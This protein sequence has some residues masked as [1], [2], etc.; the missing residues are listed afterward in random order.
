MLRTIT[1]AEM[2]R[3]ETRVM[4]NT[5]LSGERLMQNAAAHVARAVKRL[6]AGRQGPVICFCGNG[7]NGG[8]GLAAMRM[9]A[10]EDPSFEGACRMLS[11]ALSPDAQRE[12]DRLNAR[13]PH[14]A[15]TGLEAPAISRPACVIDAL[16]GTGL[17]RPLEGEALAACRQINAWRAQGVP[18]VAVDIPSGLSGLT[19][20]VL[21]EAVRATVTVTFHRPK[22]G[23][24]LKEGPDYTGEIV[25]ADIGLT[26]P[27][28]AAYDDAG[29][30]FVRQRS[31][32]LLPARRR[33]AHKG[34]FGKV[35]LWV[36]SRGMA[37]A[38]ALCATAALRT[39]AGLV[40]VA[41]PEAVV[42]VVQTLCP[43]ATCLPLPEDAEAAWALLQDKL[44]WADAL[45]AGCG[46]GT[47]AWAKALLE[48]LCVWMDGHA[49]PAVLDA[50]ALNLLSASG[51]R[52]SGVWITP[53]PAEAARLLG[54]HTADVLAEPLSAARELARRYGPTV[55][56]GA[57]SVLCAQGEMALNPFGTPAMAKGGSGDALT[58][59]LA[60]L[61]AGRAAGAYDLAD[62]ALLQTACALHGLAGE[63][64]ERRF[65]ERGV[66]ATDLCACLGLV[67][68]APP[69]A[70][71][72]PQPSGPLC[73]WVTVTVE[74]P[75]GT[76]EDGPLK[77]RY[78]ANFGYIQEVLA[79]ENEWQDACVLGVDGPVEWMEGEVSALAT[80]EDGRQIWIVSPL[81][82][83]LEA[84]AV[85]QTLSF[86][87]PVRDIV[88]PPI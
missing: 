34:C 20:H 72:E 57:C 83:R 82:A 65:G 13:A 81:G 87:G 19:G 42:D 53:H 45:G 18:V 60:A 52:P 4:Q 80:L 84:E 48:R 40:V 22:P 7:N 1:P 36:G 75:R 32:P 51:Q 3:V 71:R 50:D 76:L 11:G 15:V 41:C 21:G 17:S 79:D 49:L 70:E 23:L 24:Y 29:G 14:I 88:L 61:L 9:L 78:P 43:C 54:K 27:E 77:R 10:E 28:A 38:A 8:D 5:A 67:E 55:L 64:A 56:K 59:V 68:S 31:D 85:R 44:S 33:G 35:L 74:H 73:R 30:L 6:S 37:G 58:G 86:L 25:V 66:L 26:A 12:R 2:K 47:G 62:L 39:G 63:M 46:L 16:F 69:E